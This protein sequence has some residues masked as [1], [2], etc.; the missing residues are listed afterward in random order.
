M[1]APFA[2]E[3]VVVA[4]PGGRAKVARD[5]ALFGVA[6]V[7]AALINPFGIEGLLFPVRLLGLHALSQIGEWAPETFAKPNALE[8]TL[9]GLIGLALH[10]GEVI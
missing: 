7:A 4:P 5:W 9:L 1:V 8:A 2:L 6:S 3:A 10:V